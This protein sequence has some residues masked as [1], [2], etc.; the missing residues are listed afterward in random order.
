[1]I[2]W[3]TIL[4]KPQSCSAFVLKVPKLG[5]IALHKVANHRSL[6]R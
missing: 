6:L 5:I 4:R 3:N 1:M 2:C